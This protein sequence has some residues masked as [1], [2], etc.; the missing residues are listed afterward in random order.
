MS[1]KKTVKGQNGNKLDAWETEMIS[2]KHLPINF[3]HLL[4]G[5]L[6]GVFVFTPSIL[7]SVSEAQALQ[8]QAI[9]RIE[10]YIDHFRRTFDRSSLR[11]ELIQA[12]RELEASIALF[13][14]A[15][16]LDG[17]GH[18]LVKLGDNHRYLDNWDAAMT[19][20]EEA[21]RI[22]REAHTPAVECKALLGHARALL[23][24]KMATGAALELVTQ[25]L[26]VAEQVD[27]HSHIFDAW[28]LLAQIQLG[29]GDLVGAADSMNRAFS[30]EKAIQDDKLLYYGYLDRADVYQKFAE[31]CDYQRDFKPC[32][33]AV[34][35]AR[36]DYEAAL[37]V[38]RKLH[39]DG[40]ADQTRGFI[41]R[42]D[43]RKELIKGQ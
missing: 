33:D 26:P 39:W 1:K 2:V 7:A 38:A 22:A 13:R 14:G 34:D 6:F 42:L 24:G 31:K 11:Q 29:Q 43:I 8:Q 27:D 37:A 28:D 40:L 25:A 41:K 35:R 9:Q 5:I 19:A 17:A 12:Q 20:Y 16:V 4:L 36:R 30:F 21:A 23:Y 15:G 3:K 18:S 32:L 10:R